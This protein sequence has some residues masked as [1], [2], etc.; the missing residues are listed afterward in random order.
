[1]MYVYIYIYIYIH[2]QTHISLSLSIYIYIH[3]HVCVYVICMCVYVCMYVYIYIYMYVCMYIYI[4]IYICT[5]STCLSLECSPERGAKDPAKARSSG[6]PIE[7]EREWAVQTHVI[8]YGIQ[9]YHTLWHGIVRYNLLQCNMQYN[10]RSPLPPAIVCLRGWRSTVEIVMFE[11]SNS[12]KPYPSVFSCI[13]RR[14]EAR[15]MFFEP[16]HLD[17]VS[18]RIPPTSQR[19]D[20][21]KRLGAAWHEITKQ[22]NIFLSLSLS[23]YVYIYIYAHTYMYIVT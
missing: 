2:I 12:M 4:Y 19:L 15:D 18:N 7:T 16:Q 13:Y 10:D 17:E 3:T 20:D 1:M 14:V 11:I 5:H 23:V 9:Y 21:A 8:W 6:Q 22:H